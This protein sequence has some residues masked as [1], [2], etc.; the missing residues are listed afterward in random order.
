MET[1]QDE[2]QI[3][4]PDERFRV[5]DEGS[6]NFVVRKVIESRRYRDHVEEWAAAELRRAQRQEGFFLG[7]WGL[8]LEEWARSQIAQQ[9]RRKSLALPAGTV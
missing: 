6:A 8:E 2:L 4:I 9:F 5:V 1:E 7:R 3:E